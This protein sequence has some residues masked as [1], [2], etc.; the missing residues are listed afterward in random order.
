MR[1]GRDVEP[2]ERR[3]HLG[4]LLEELGIGFVARGLPCDPAP[5]R[6]PGPCQVGEGAPVRRAVRGQEKAFPLG[7]PLETRGLGPG[8]RVFYRVGD[9]KEQVRQTRGRAR[10][11][12]QERNRQRKSSARSRKQFVKGWHAHSLRDGALVD[13]GPQRREHRERERRE[14]HEHRFQTLLVSAIRID[15][16]RGAKARGAMIFRTLSSSAGASPGWLQPRPSARPVPRS[17]SSKPS[18]DRCPLFAASSSTRPA[19]APSERWAS[20]TSFRPISAS[21]CK[22]SR[23]SRAPIASPCCC[24]TPITPPPVSASITPRW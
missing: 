17:R 8:P 22:V 14:A 15:R 5:A 24:P 12:R 7:E 3:Q 21:T 13:F 2:R 10:R 11:L 16:G 9:A 18:R 19:Y 6:R 23:P 1:C 20:T 4:H